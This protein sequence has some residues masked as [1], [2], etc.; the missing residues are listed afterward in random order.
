M[1]VHACRACAAPSRRTSVRTPVLSSA[2]KV[3]R[4]GALPAGRNGRRARRSAPRGSSIVAV[5]LLRTTS[6]RL[7][8]CRASSGTAS[9][10]RSARRNV[11]ARVAGYGAPALVAVARARR[12]AAVQRRVLGGRDRDLV[13]RHR[14]LDPPLDGERSAASSRLARRPSSAALARRRRPRRAGQDAD[15]HARRR[16]VRWRR[17]GRRRGR[18]ST[19]SS[20][21]AVNPVAAGSAQSVTSYVPARAAAGANASSTT[22]IRSATRTARQPVRSPRVLQALRGA[23]R[24]SRPRAAST[25]RSRS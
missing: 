8:R 4:R 16:V 20:V 2:P 24:A 23:I 13:A 5:A 6:A 12:D 19:G 15:V 17:A 22:P 7:R 18:A 11:I 3:T 14:L 25:A 21:C 10:R 1:S 9:S